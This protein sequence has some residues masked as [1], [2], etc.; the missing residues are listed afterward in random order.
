MAD[1]DVSRDE[2]LMPSDPKELA[3]ALLQSGDRKAAVEAGMSYEDYVAKKKEEA[4][5][6]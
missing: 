6:R 5:A 1:T 2:R 4:D 3:R